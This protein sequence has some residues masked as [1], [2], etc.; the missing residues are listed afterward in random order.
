MA[1]MG[2]NEAIMLILVKSQNFTKLIK[3]VADFIQVTLVGI[4]PFTFSGERL[5]R[6]T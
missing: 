6:G 5:G 4:L 3:N 2:L 1:C